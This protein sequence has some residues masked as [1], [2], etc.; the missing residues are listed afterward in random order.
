MNKGITA[1][2][3]CGESEDKM[4]NESKLR[5]K[6]THTLYG[7][8]QHIDVEPD[9]YVNEIISAIK[10]NPFDVMVKKQNGGQ[11]D[12]DTLLSLLKSR[13]Y[14]FLDKGKFGRAEI[15][16]ELIDNIEN[17]KIIDY[18]YLENCG[19]SLANE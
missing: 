15:L 12:K 19:L 5:E 8:A 18:A 16:K 11:I 9:E 3:T 10:A 13:R 1:K 14:G 4:D 2:L 6:I 17:G 7:F